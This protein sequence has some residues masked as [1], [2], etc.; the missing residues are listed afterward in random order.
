MIKKILF[1]FFT[2]AL[3]TCLLFNAVATAQP[4]PYIPSLSVPLFVDAGSLL[5][6]VSFQ[7]ANAGGGTLSWSIG[8][9]AYKQA[10]GWIS[11]I[12]PRSGTTQKATTVTISITREGFARGIYTATM[13]VFSNGGNAQVTVSMEVAPP[14]VNT[15]HLEFGETL[16]SMAFAIKNYTQSP[17]FWHAACVDADNKTVAWVTL[18]PPQGELSAGDN[19]SVSVSVDRNGLEPGQ[20]TATVKV[21][22]SIGDNQGVE[23]VAISMT[24]PDTNPPDQCP[25]ALALA[26]EGQRNLLTLRAFRDQVLART[27]WG[28][29]GI[30][31]YY[32]HRQELFDAFNRYPAL[33]KFAAHLVRCILPLL[34]TTSAAAL[35]TPLSQ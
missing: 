1:H 6:Q 33:K 32:C 35:P 24:V 22:I 16:S 28:A 13:P 14:F 2:I 21:T 19:Q 12:E 15:S 31:W 5:S 9:I 34:Q 26:S 17:L 10:G 23:Q 7:I 29:A 30:R 27:A 18:S 20:Y 4:S 25:I 11:A 3:L 8:D